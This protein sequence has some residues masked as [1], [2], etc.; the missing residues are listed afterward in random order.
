MAQIIDLNVDM[1]LDPERHKSMMIKDDPRDGGDLLRIKDRYKNA[2]KRLYEKDGW[3]DTDGRFPKL[4]V[5][6]ATALEAVWGG[7]AIDFKAPCISRNLIR[8]YGQYMVNFPAPKH[9]GRWEGAGPHLGWHKH[10]H[11]FTV[12]NWIG[13][14]LGPD[15]HQIA[16]FDSTGMAING[17]EGWLHGSYFGEVGFVGNNPGWYDPSYTEYGLRLWDEAEASTIGSLW[18]ADFNGYCIDIIRSTPLNC[19]GT[20]SVFSSALGGIALSDGEMATINLGVVSGDDNPALLVQR[21]KYGRGAGGMVT[22]RLAKSEGGKRTP[23]KAQ[24][25]LWQL[26]PCVGCTSIDM[27]Q[28]DMNFK[29]IHAPFIMNSRAWGQTLMV[30][31]YVGWNN[32]AILHDITNRKHWPNGSYHP[33]VFGWTSRNGGVLRDII[34]GEAL[35]AQAVNSDKRLGMVDVGAPFDYQAGTPVYSILGPGTTPPAANAPTIQKFSTNTPVM[36][37]GNAII[38]WE[39]TNATSVTITPAITTTPLPVDGSAVVGPITATTVYRMVATG[40][41]GTATVDLT[42]QYQAPIPAGR[43]RSKWSVIVF[44]KPDNTPAEYQLY[45]KDKIHDANTNTWWHSG[46]GMVDGQVLEIALGGTAT[47]II[48]L[49]FDVPLDYPNDF[50]TRFDVEHWNGST[51]VKWLA[52]GTYSGGVS[53][54]AMRTT[55]VSASKIRI[56][57]RFTR[58]SWWGIRDLRILFQG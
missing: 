55:P 37:G 48:G 16:C 36:S 40:P 32:K 50:P 38:E 27:V 31:G 25:V 8:V 19:I 7:H 15:R 2:Y 3:R 45:T 56:R 9:M 18:A 46:T 17:N 22:A 28:S 39:T 26:D 47:G 4:T 21:S 42:I 33:M 53:S 54:K 43:D 49:E 1:G 52:T 6:S 10:H 20:M 41:G 23:N 14:W 13:E 34:L 58:G 44:N 11:A 12:Q 30:S 35:G 51:W 57:N 29:D 24:A 5:F